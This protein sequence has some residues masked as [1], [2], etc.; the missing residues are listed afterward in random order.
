MSRKFT[1][2]CEREWLLKLDWDLHEQIKDRTGKMLLSLGDNDC[3]LLAELHTDFAL[4]VD[5]LWIMCEEQ[6]ASKGVVDDEKLTATRKFAK[7]LGG[8]VLEQA[9]TALVGAVID[10]FPNPAQRAGL[11]TLMEKARQ[12]STLMTE[13]MVSQIEA[14]NPEQ[15]A[16]TCIDLAGNTRR[17]PE[18]TLGVIR[19]AS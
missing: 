8:D 15:L 18:S 14:L 9:A 2:N 1:D 3:E 16:K 12:T 10:F 4:L 11:T 5:I 6:A 19:S 7:G 17:S 13:Q